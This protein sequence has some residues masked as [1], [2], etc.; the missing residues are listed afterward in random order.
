[1][2][3]NQRKWMRLVLIIIYLFPPG[4]LCTA[5]LRNF[6]SFKFYRNWAFQGPPH[7]ATACGIN[8]ESLF[9]P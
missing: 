4:T 8:S 1:M 9:H 5:V 7:R 3:E 6:M 2:Q